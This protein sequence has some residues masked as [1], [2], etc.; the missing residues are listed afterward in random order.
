MKKG[1]GTICSKCSFVE[2]DGKRCP[3][4]GAR[5]TAERSPETAERDRF[6]HTAAWQRCRTWWLALEADANQYWYCGPLCWECKKE[7]RVEIATE[8]DHIVSR[9]KGGPDFEPSNLMSLCKSCHSKKTR[10]EQL[11]VA[12]AGAS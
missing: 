2:R 1:V 8:V 6:Y 10:A 3:E 7:N 5:G 4:H 12:D 11:E 9:S